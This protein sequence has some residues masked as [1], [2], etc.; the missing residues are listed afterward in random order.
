L[1][2]FCIENAVAKRLSVGEQN[3]G[4]TYVFDNPEIA[5]PCLN[6]KQMLINIFRAICISLKSVVTLHWR[7]RGHAVSPFFWLKMGENKL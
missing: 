1:P 7:G 4:E 5:K 2:R 3:L 6:C